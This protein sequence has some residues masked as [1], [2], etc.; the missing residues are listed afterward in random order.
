MKKRSLIALACSTLVSACAPEEQSVIAM[1]YAD[2]VEIGGAYDAGR[3]YKCYVKTTISAIADR[4]R[5]KI[6]GISAKIVDGNEVI[7]FSPTKDASDHILCLKHALPQGYYTII[8][9]A[10]WKR[11]LEQNAILK[12]PL[13][14]NQLIMETV[15]SANWVR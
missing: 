7:Y 13:D 11:K 15:T 3:S 14:E 9:R 10:A 12:F 5:V 8:R 1:N 6:L 2:R 4:C